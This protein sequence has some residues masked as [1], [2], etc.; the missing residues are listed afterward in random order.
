MEG[1]KREAG[2]R[3]RRGIG[4]VGRKSGVYIRGNGQGEGGKREGESGGVVYMNGDEN[5][6]EESDR[7]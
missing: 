7:D 3:E 1:G 6:D 5:R 4:A 2:E